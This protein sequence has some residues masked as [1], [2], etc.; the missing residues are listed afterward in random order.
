MSR[1]F[2]HWLFTAIY[3]LTQII[4]S[5]EPSLM[6]LAS[7]RSELDRAPWSAYDQALLM[8]P[9]RE[10]VVILDFLDGLDCYTLALQLRLASSLWISVAPIQCPGVWV[11]PE[12]TSMTIF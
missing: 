2:L 4:E 7:G 6:A 5:I 1:W 10:W 12:E 11:D 8:K 3:P 9:R